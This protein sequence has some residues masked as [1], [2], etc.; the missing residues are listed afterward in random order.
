MGRYRRENH[1]FRWSVLHCGSLSTSR[2]TIPALRQFESGLE[3]IHLTY[4]LSSFLQLLSSLCRTCHRFRSSR[5]LLSSKRS[6][7]SFLSFLLVC[8]DCKILNCIIYLIPFFQYRGLFLIL[9]N[10]MFAF[11]KNL[12]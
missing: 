4:F 10:S 2:P 1:R 6:F 11:K 5:S 12:T 8:F 3:I 9:L 7:L